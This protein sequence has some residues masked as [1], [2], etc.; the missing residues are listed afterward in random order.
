MTVPTTSK[1]QQHDPLSDAVTD[2]LL[3][4]YTYVDALVDW[5]IDVFAKGKYKYL[6]ELNNIVLCG[7]DQS[8]D[9]EFHHGRLGLEAGRRA[10]KNAS[11]DFWNGRPVLATYFQP[12]YK[13]RHCERIV[14]LLQTQNNRAAVCAF[15]LISTIRWFVIY[16]FPPN[17]MFLAGDAGAIPNNSGAARAR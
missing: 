1:R 6:P 12:I 14:I 9:A 10:S 16:R 4:G 2:N 15:L 13:R 7:P 5:G 17:N 11:P 3:A 8:Q